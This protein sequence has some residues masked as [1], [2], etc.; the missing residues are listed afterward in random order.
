LS[1]VSGLPL[2]FRI[3]DKLTL[4]KPHPCGSTSWRVVRVGADIGLVCE[5]CQHRV[6]IERR[7]LERRVKRFDERGPKPGEEGA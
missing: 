1:N 3:G 4:G 5:G 6:L 2:E 7:Q